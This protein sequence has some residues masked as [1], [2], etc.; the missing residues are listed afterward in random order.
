MK[1]IYLASEAVPFIKTGGLA[2]VV[3]ALPKQMARRGHEVTIIIPKYD[4]IKLEYLQKIEYVDTVELNGEIY[5]LVRYFDN[6][7]NYLF[8]ENKNFYERGRIYGD[9]DEDVQYANFCELVLRFI[10]KRKMRV[11]IVHC[12]DWQTGPFSYFLKN[13]YK[14]DPFFFDTR[15][16]YSIHNLMYQGKFSNYA[17]KNL[18]Y[19]N[20]PDNINYMAIGIEY[21]DVVS[22]VS[23]S[24]ATEIKYPYFSEGLEWIIRQRNIQGIL[25][26]IDYELFDPTDSKDIIPFE[27]NLQKFKKENRKLLLDSF[28]LDIDDNVS[29]IISL[30][31]RLVEGK[32]L[33]LIEARIEEILK[34]DS[35]KLI[36]IGSGDKKYEDFF[37]YLTWKY[38]DKCKVYIGYNEKLANI[39][40]AGSDLFIMPSRYEPCGLS[41]MI[42]M[43]FGTVPLV[44][45]TGGLRD[46]VKPFNE[47]DGKGNGF[48]FTCF[49]AD[50]MLYTIRY[51]ENIFFDKKEIW[52]KLV[53]TNFI[54]D[55]SWEKSALEYEKLYEYAK[56]TP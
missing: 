3:Y 4:K 51:A 2:D 22:T 28:G 18:G 37:N 43:R 44:R 45:E 1:I 52:N 36:I 27:G 23:P 35:V 32:G 15:V 31:S 26:G 21:A 24:Y 48:S 5:N 10:K 13:R 12:N 38:P 19:Y 50:D 53:E 39:A 34:Y 54:L 46:T 56:T 40:Y 7:I 9:F 6:E 8:I 30:V 41:Q 29:M 11:D 49:N 17:F 25:N 47:K 55:N 14:S 20:L 33:D 16:V 42:S